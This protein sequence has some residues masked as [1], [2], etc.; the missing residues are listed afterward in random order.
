[1]NLRLA[2]LKTGYFAH[3]EKPGADFPAVH[4]IKILEPYLVEF[5]LCDAVIPKGHEYQ[6]CSSS[7]EYTYVDCQ[8]C[9]NLLDRMA[10]AEGH[11]R[12]TLF[13]HPKHV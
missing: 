10:Q 13:R 6:W 8:P 4:V 2:D 1:M 5:P 9:R 7:V 11:T 3:P 12:L